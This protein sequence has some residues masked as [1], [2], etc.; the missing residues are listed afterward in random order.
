MEDPILSLEPALASSPMIAVVGLGCWYPGIRGPGQLWENVLARRQEFRRMPDSRMRRH[1]YFDPDPATPDKTYGQRAALIDGFRFDWAR[2]RI[3]Q[4]TFASTDIVHWLALEVADQALKNAGFSTILPCER[5]GVIVGNTLTGEQTRAQSL[6]LRW[7]FVR[8]ALEAAA[9]VRGLPADLRDELAGSMEELFKSA[10]APVTEDTLAGALSNTIAGRICN[11]FDF[12]GGGYTVDGACC[13]SLLAICT[14]ANLLSSRD[15]DMALVGGVDISLDA[16]EMVGFAKTGALSAGDMRV[17]DRRADGFIPGEGC[18]FVVLKRLADALAAGDKTYAVIR[19]WGVS[20][21]GKGGLMTPSRAGQALALKRAYDKAGFCPDQLD[22]IEGHGTGTRV[23]DAVELDAI[24]SMLGADASSRRCG[25]TSFKSIVGHTKAAAGVG[26]FIKAVIAVNRRVLPPTAGC[27]QPS[28]VFDKPPQGLYPIL[29]GQILPPEAKVRCGVSAMGFGGINAHVMLESAGIPWAELAPALGERALLASHQ[30]S[31]VF[32]FG[33]SDLDHLQGELVRVAEF[34]GQLSCGDLT[35]LAAHLS[36]HL[37]TVCPARAAVIAETADELAE[38]LRAVAERLRQESL[39]AGEIAGGP[40]GAWWLSWRPK[41]TRLGFAFPGQGS[42]Q[43]GM[44]RILVERY[45]WARDLAVRADQWL[46]EAGSAPITPVLFRPLDRASGPEQLQQW[47]EALAQTEVA[48]P[49]VCLASLLYAQLLARLGVTPAVVAGHSLGELTAL[50][51]AGALDDETFFRLAAVRGQLMASSDG[52][53]GAMASLACSADVAEDWCARVPGYLVVANHNSLRQSVISGDERAV[54]A[55]IQRASGQGMAAKRLPVSG[56]FHSSMMSQATQRLRAQDWLPRTTSLTIPV[57]SSVSGCA[58]PASLD[59]A[60]HLAA[61][62]TAPV[63]WLDVVQS[64]RDQCDLLIEVGPG[65]VLSGLV[66]DI[67]GPDGPTCLPVAAKANASRDLNQV[68]ARTFIQGVD[69][70]W[71]E[72]YVSRLVRPLVPPSQRLFIDN[73]C[74]RPFAGVPR[75]VAPTT[76]RCSAKAS[77]AAHPV[78]VTD[79][80]KLVLNLAAERTGFSGDSIALEARLLDDLNLDSIKA[81]ELVA[82][83]AK[84]A[85]AAGKLDPSQLANATLEEV[86][87]AVRAALTNQAEEIPGAADAH[88]TWVRDFAIEYVDMAQ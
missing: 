72:L 60:S 22:F 65:Q 25:V 38:R 67:N 86:T 12:R 66:A 4:A 48:Q 15:L 1:D 76:T 75:E 82:A 44:A 42:Q 29:Q 81:A 19:G 45:S 68:L 8:R 87:M 56:A 14:A 54:A 26:A 69:V 73:P 49:A 10:F 37:P 85:G 83:V 61:Q 32:V 80:E 43:L 36:E 71:Q 18:G 59:L 46:A 16:F 21:D 57:F 6:R 27:A 34:A 41:R 28:A 31:E 9:S 77:P 58:L 88:D 24:A 11:Y 78:V 70:R 64:L 13:S 74:E 2:R 62:L 7:P 30:D 84:L 47:G 33:A 55:V 17:Y 63:K 40:R 3:P 53:R 23:G 52:K 51:L 39:R 20:S 5:T 79:L 50:R 35:D